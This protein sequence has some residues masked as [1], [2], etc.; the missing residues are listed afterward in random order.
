MEV[1]E[2]AHLGLWV[3]RGFLQA[4]FLF[5]GAGEG[6]NLP[7]VSASPTNG[8]IGL[9]RRVQREGGSGG[10]V[11]GRLCCWNFSRKQRSSCSLCG[12][13]QCLLNQIEGRY[14][15][16]P[17]QTHFKRDWII[18]D[19]PDPAVTFEV[20]VCHWGQSCSLTFLP[21]FDLVAARTQCSQEAAVWSQCEQERCHN[22]SQ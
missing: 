1:M 18:Q 15:P 5:L 13:P 22:L 20:L 3:L 9:Q 6:K 10:L 8:I 2:M 19:P 16:M 11:Q 7:T 4:C 14:L 21:L 17:L 12:T